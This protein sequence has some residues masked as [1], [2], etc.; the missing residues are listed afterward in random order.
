MA[1]A[2]A[3]TGTT[4]TAETDAPANDVKIEDVGPAKKRL[5]ITVP[6]DVV[7]ERIGVSID[8]LAAQTALPGFRKGRAPKALLER[9]FGSALR[10]ETRNQLIADAYSQAIEKHQLRPVGDPEPAT[11]MDEIKLEDG[12]PLTFSVDVEVVPEFELPSLDGIE[13]KRPILEITEEHIENEIERQRT[14]FG[15]V[16]EIEGDFQ[17]NDRIITYATAT[18]KGEDEPF[19]QHDDVLVIHPGDDEGAG[20]VLGLMIDGLAGK[21]K[22]KRAGDTVEI[23]TTAPEGHE[24]EDIR[25]KELHIVLQIR[26]AERITPAEV[27]QVLDQYGLPSE[28]VLR[29]QIKMALDQRLQQEQLGA[30]REQLYDY[31]ADSVDFELPER[32]SAAQAER[33]LKQH[34]IDL[35]YRGLSPE[36]VEEHLA[37][38]RGQSVDIARRRLK[39][40]FLMQRLGE[41]FKIEV[42]EQEINGRIAGIAA[43]RGARPEQLRNELAQAGR[44]AEVGLQIREHKTADRIIGQSKVTDITAEQW[45]E[46]VA[47]KQAGG[48]QPSKKK[49]TK[50]KTAAKSESAAPSKKKTTKKKKKTT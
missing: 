27:Q 35:L 49:T 4:G 15:E 28:D 43:Q 29:E 23:N 26:R 9:R 12:K 50:K 46:I 38:A 36:E 10:E 47:A 19:F 8:T 11:P 22:G 16:N 45:Q 3:T 37:K 48:A 1:E 31:L 6:A 21:L 13:I 33:V 44:L 34:E 30:M 2:T 24:R 14:N 7:S 40:F 32:L 41:H 42:S 20:Q 17:K 25:G 18:R 39:L 5:T